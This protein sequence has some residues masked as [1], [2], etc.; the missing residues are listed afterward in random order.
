MTQGVAVET[1]RLILRA[2]VAADR[3]VLHAMWADPQVMATL[4]PV[5]SAADSD[6]TIERHRGYGRVGLGFWVVERRDTGEAIG[7]CGLKPGAEDTPIAGEVE[8]GWLIARDHW[9][10]G[11]AREASAATLDWAWAN[12]DAPRVVAIT[13]ARNLPSQALMSELGMQRLH[14]LDFIHPAHARNPAL[15]ETVVFAIDRPD[16]S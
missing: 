16:A 11:F 10:Q 8:I 1:E 13:A 2:P 14:D 4:G 12:T 3:P 6:A 15:R 7:F 9:R 5:K